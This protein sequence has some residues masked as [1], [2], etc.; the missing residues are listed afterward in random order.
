MTRHPINIGECNLQGS[1]GF[2]KVLRFEVL[3]VLRGSILFEAPVEPAEPVEPEPEPVEPVE[4]VEP[5]R[6]LEPV[7]TLVTLSCRRDAAVAR[8]RASDANTGILQALALARQLVLSRWE[9]FHGIHTS[10]RDGGDWGPRGRPAVRERSRR[11]AA[12][13]RLGRRSTASR[14]ICPGGSRVR[15]ANVP[16]RERASRRARIRRGRSQDVTAAVVIC[17]E[18]RRAAAIC[19]AAAEWQSA[20]RAAAA[21]R[22]TTPVRRPALRGTAIR[23]RQVRD[24]AAI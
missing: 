12:S 23:H 9:N 16:L 10:H 15:V 7:R 5:G 19:R 14:G 22:G 13:G 1:T 4:P 2:C 21:G 3:Q 18:R 8:N 11:A 24:A 6:T 20:I 17:A